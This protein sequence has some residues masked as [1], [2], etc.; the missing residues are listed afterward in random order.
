MRIDSEEVINNAI[1][2]S[3]KCNFN[4]LDNMWNLLTEALFG[5]ETIINTLKMLITKEIFLCYVFLLAYVNLYN[6]L[7]KGTSETEML[8][9]WF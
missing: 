1:C 4:S 7:I 5:S 9:H 6:Q 2:L 8:Y 3:D